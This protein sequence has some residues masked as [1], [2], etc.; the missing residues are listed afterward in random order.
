M[1]QRSTSSMIFEMND[2]RGLLSQPCDDVSLPAIN[3]IMHRR[4]TAVVS[5]K[6]V[7]ASFHEFFDHQRMSSF[8][9]IMQWSLQQF[10]SGLDIGISIQEELDDELVAFLGCNMQRR[11]FCFLVHRV[12]DLLAIM[13]SQIHENLVHISRCHNFHECLV[14]VSVAW[15]RWCLFDEPMHME[16]ALLQ[17]LDHFWL[18]LNI[19]IF[20]NVGLE[21]DREGRIH[22]RAGKLLST[23]SCKSF[24]HKFV[25]DMLVGLAV[26]DD[27]LKCQKLSLLLSLIMQWRI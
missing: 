25:D 10:I 21:V 1:M 4:S 11:L 20:A 15:R 3:S 17:L 8:T 26:G 7:S 6:H 22:H 18:V 14:L 23:Q 24:L 19:P 12:Q 27:V 9:C 16:L 2:V 5:V 13:A